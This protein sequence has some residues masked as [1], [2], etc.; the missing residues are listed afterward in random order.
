[1]QFLRR[2]QFLLCFLAVLV[3]A[4]VMVVHQ[5]LTN[6]TAHIEAREDFILHANRGDL[7]PAEHVYQLLIQDL[8]SLNE[9]SLVEDLERT[10]MLVDPKTPEPDN[11]VWKYYVGVKKEI[12]RRS[13]QRLG[14]ALER[15]DGK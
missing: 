8:P 3:F 12:Q 15:A 7:K 1:V 4:S 2:H 11:L 13:E 5:F 6:Q 10:S 9:R 14:R